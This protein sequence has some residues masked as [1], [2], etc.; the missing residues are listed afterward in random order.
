MIVAI[1]CDKSNAALTLSY[2]FL[3]V[4][5]FLRPRRIDPY[6]IVFLLCMQ[7]R[8]LVTDMFQLTIIDLESEFENHIYIVRDNRNYK[9]STRVFGNKGQDCYFSKSVLLLSII[10]YILYLDCRSCILEN[11]FATIIIDDEPI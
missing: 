10:I 2:I 9:L 6:F 7:L 4:W 8:I 1:L 3:A 11:D 5:H